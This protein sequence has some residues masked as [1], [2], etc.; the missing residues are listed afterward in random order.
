MLAA[1]KVCRYARAVRFRCKRFIR[2]IRGD[3]GSVAALTVPKEPFHQNEPAFL[4]KH[5]F[6][7]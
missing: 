3:P 6:L 2:I 7:M 4:K 5:E 1:A